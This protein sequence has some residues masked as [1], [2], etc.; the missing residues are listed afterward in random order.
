MVAHDRLLER[1]SFFVNWRTMGLTHSHQGELGRSCEGLSAAGEGGLF[2]WLCVCLFFSNVFPY[3]LLCFTFFAAFC[4][5][6]PL[7]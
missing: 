6:F 2:V 3:D 7:V 5:G 4:L 1:R